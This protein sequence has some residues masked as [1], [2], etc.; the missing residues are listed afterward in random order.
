MRK[1][2]CAPHCSNAAG[3]PW[4]SERRLSFHKWVFGGAHWGGGC[5]ALAPLLCSGLLLGGGRCPVPPATD[6]LQP[7]QSLCLTPS[8]TLS[9]PALPSTSPIL[10]FYK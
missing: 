10:S 1:A 3:Q 4:A 9:P 6:C 2:G 7:P 8:L 5:S